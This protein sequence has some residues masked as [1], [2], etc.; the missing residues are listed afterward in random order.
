MLLFKRN[1]AW[2]SF[3]CWSECPV[4]LHSSKLHDRW[5]DFLNHSEVNRCRQFGFSSV[6]T[7]FTLQGW[8]NVGV[9][10]KKNSPPCTQRVCVC[11]WVLILIALQRGVGVLWGAL[12]PPAYITHSN[13]HTATVP[14]VIRGLV[15]FAYWWLASQASIF[16]AI[17][18]MHCWGL[19]TGYLVRMIILSWVSQPHQ[20]AVQR[21]DSQTAPGEGQRD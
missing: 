11:T 10:L 17:T 4:Q 7:P 18:Q 6:P 20:R 14:E 16:T 9:N 13:F 15:L 3:S 12:A 8:A 21:G 2:E 5:K 1:W 19:V